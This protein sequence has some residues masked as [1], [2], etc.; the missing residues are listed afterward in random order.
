MIKPNYNK[1]EVV[2]TGFE[3]PKK[4]PTVRIKTRGLEIPFVAYENS[5]L[6]MGGEFQRVFTH[7]TISHND[8]LANQDDALKPGDEFMSARARR[9]TTWTHSSIVKLTLLEWSPPV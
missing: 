5:L 4:S 1:E 8:I 9:M 7:R 2:R 6:V 3:I